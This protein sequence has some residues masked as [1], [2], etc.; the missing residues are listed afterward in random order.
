MIKAAQAFEQTFGK[1]APELEQGAV[2]DAIR[3]EVTAL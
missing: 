2:A 1:E 3:Q